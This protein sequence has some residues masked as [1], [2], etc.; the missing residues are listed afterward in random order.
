MATSLISCLH[1]TKLSCIMK[2]VQLE[3]R[4]ERPLLQRLLRLWGAGE[5]E[6]R[7]WPQAVA[8]T[9]WETKPRRALQA[10]ADLPVSCRYDSL[11]LALSSAAH[12]TAQKEMG[13]EDF[14]E[15]EA[16]HF[17][18]CK[19]DECLG[20]IRCN[21]YSLRPGDHT[22]LSLGRK[23]KDGGFYGEYLWSDPGIP[24]RLVQTA[25]LLSQ[26]IG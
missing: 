15:K 7:G 12:Y 2:E 26:I 1:L 5:G 3:L 17:D 13:Q 22:R 16:E 9:A 24:C 14:L 19:K 20:Q 8:Q 18:S 10:R 23:V 11:V 4:R 6:R 25:V 21:S